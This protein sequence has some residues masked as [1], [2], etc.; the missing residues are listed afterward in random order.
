MDEIDPL[1]LTLFADGDS[2]GPGVSSSIALPAASGSGMTISINLSC[3]GIRE[4]RILP[5]SELAVLGT[6][7]RV[8]PR[9]IE[10]K[11]ASEFEAE[12]AVGETMISSSQA[13]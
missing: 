10:A 11:L 1:R 13:G 9:L 7:E 4:G 3:R 8:L 2:G 6:R 5:A 12:I